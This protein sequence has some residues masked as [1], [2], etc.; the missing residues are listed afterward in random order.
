M[1]KMK[2][3]S[4]INRNNP[5]FVSALERGLEV[6]KAFGADA[7]GLTLSEVAIRTGL[8]RGTARRFLLTLHALGYLRLEGK[9]FHLAPKALDLGYAY[10]SSLPIWKAA[11]PIMKE[12][13][14]TLGESCS[15]GVL[16]GVDVVYIARQPPKH[17]TFSP[18]NVGMRMP[19]YI[20]AMGRVLLAG[21]SPSQ[22]DDYF[23]RAILKKITAH[24]VASEP[25]LRTLLKKISAD[26][27]ALAERQAD[28]GILSIAVPVL[29][30]S[31][32]MEFA[33][34]ASSVAGRAS[35]AD[36]K[37]RF[38]P[39]LRSAAEQLGRSF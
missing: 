32:R 33:L 26:Q 29:S 18:I 24:T 8:T 22:L 39:V 5:D 20:N 19:A 36:L 21:L 2:I 11:H 14:E 25:A 10:L 12:V 35:K 3:P 15:L 27:Y 13:T 7:D 34:N 28:V 30:R 38:L 6:I 23:S 9:T 4:A 16:D 31:G 1:L 17:S 37:G